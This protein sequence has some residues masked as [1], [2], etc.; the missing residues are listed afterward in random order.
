MPALTPDKDM[1]ADANFLPIKKTIS[2]G[3]RL[4]SLEAPLV[5]GILNNTPDSFYDGGKYSGTLDS[6]LVQAAKHVEEG[7]AFLDIG[8]YST[9]PGADEI[10]EAEELDRVL[11]VIEALNENFPDTIISIDTFRASV[12]RQAVKAGAQMVND[13]SGGDDDP[14]MF[15]AVAEL[16]VPYIL[17][18]KKGSPKTMQA[19]P[20]YENVVTE[21][22]EHLSRRLHT[23]RSLGVNDIIID[24][25]FGFGKTL[26]HNNRLLHNLR[27]FRMLG[28]PV[29]AGVSR[30]GM[31]YR[32]LK[33]NPENALNGT[34]AAHVLALLQGVSL[35]RV[36]D[37]KEAMEAIKIVNFYRDTN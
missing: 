35:L 37:V 29:L 13:I 11:P 21:V 6:V 27:L 25:G 26:E 7:A 30:K 10:S 9:R 36:H 17:M 34:T 3:G 22:M 14:D 19:D 33:T 5:M 32:L 16:R 2:I 12:A 24:P 18:H 8:G 4:I 1:F 23:L 20:Q 28:Q 15:A 31:I